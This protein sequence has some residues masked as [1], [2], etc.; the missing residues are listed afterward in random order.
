MVIGEKIEVRRRE[1]SAECF[2]LLLVLVAKA[3]EDTGDM[4]IK[5]GCDPGLGRIAN[6]GSGSSVKET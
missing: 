3:D 2:G 5:S 6:W 1:F 4:L